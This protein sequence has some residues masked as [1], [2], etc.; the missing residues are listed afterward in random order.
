MVFWCL[1]S[2]QFCYLAHESCVV[3]S[4]LMRKILN[5]KYFDAFLIIQ[6]NACT[7]KM[8]Y[9][10]SHRG[11]CYRSP[12]WDRNWNNSLL[13]VSTDF[14]SLT[15]LLQSN[16]PPYFML[17]LL[18]WWQ[19]KSVCDSAFV[20]SLVLGICSWTIW[21]SNCHYVCRNLLGSICLFILLVQQ[22]Y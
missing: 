8:L 5:C 13:C 22:V 14:I 21:D 10:F 18:N 1:V 2:S 7:Y 6:H 17:L 20:P 9:Q 3:D 16:L 11:N 19:R 15:S 12:D 4:S